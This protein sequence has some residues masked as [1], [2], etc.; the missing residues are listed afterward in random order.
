MKPVD[1]RAFFVRGVAG[2]IDWRKKEVFYEK[3][4]E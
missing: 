4:N 3:T 1:C 2:I